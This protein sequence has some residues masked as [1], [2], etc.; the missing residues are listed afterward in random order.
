MNPQHT[1]ALIR[2]VRLSRGMTQAALAEMLHISPKAVS[3]WE[4]GAGFP[5]VSMIAA[6][7][8]AL[9]V[10][11]ASLLAGDMQT[12]ETDGGNMRRLKIY[13]CSTC[14][15]ILTATNPC[16]LVCCGQRLTAMTIQNADDDHRL[17]I[18]PMEDEWHVSWTHPMEKGH[19]LAFLLEV[20]FD[21]MV[22]ARLYPEGA[23]EK[24]LPR[25]PGGKFYCACSE[26]AGVLFAHKP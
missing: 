2:R 13:R 12:N 23:C 9:G 22:V 7:S 5:D 11:E 26:D 18:A 15:N 21:T 3:K 6:L 25:L 20:G 1:G 19:Y 14:G 24:R 16:D 4:R 17:A 10:S 8:R